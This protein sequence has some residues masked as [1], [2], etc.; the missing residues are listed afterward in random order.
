MSRTRRF[1]GQAFRA[2]FTLNAELGDG[3][4][5]SPPPP[6]ISDGFVQA[7][8]GAGIVLIWDLI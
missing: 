4:R 1:M 3:Q 5:L 8:A 6:C 7:T 2:G